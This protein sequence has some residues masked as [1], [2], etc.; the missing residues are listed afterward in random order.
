M[1]ISR[2]AKK[3]LLRQ[4]C[5]WMQGGFQS[6]RRPTYRSDRNVLPEKHRFL[7]DA[8]PQQGRAS[9]RATEGELRT[10]ACRCLSMAIANGSGKGVLHRGNRGANSSLW[11]RP[12]EPDCGAGENLLSHSKDPSLLLLVASSKKENKFEGGPS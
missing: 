1:L 5:R 4:S 3:K 9:V 10:V 8:R 12:V 7:E 11:E 2:A 6:P